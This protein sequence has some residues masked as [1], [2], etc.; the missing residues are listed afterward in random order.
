MTTVDAFVAASTP[1]VMTLQALWR[2]SHA[3]ALLGILLGLQ[4]AELAQQ[5]GDR[6]GEISAVR[7]HR[8]AGEAD[9]CRLHAIRGSGRCREHWSSLAFVVWTKPRWLPAQQ[10]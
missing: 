4:H 9:R 5:P 1:A 6:R 10:S 7:I 2:A 3:D 8:L